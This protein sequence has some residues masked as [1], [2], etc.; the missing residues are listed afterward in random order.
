MLFPLRKREKIRYKNEW[1][2]V[3]PPL[4]INK[5]KIRHNSIRKNA[6][7]LKYLCSICYAE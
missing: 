3:N 4:I 7:F 5:L 1:D 2:E 6:L